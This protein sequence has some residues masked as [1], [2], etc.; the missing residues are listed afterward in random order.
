MKA[1]MYDSV[2]KSLLIILDECIKSRE[3]FAVDRTRRFAK[4]FETARKLQQSEAE[5]FEQKLKHIQ[6]ECDD[7]LKELEKV[8]DNT[9]KDK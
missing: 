6:Q 9:R 8:L 2:V 1:Y 3:T 4:E 5:A 7:K